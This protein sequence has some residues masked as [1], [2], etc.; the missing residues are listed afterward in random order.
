MKDYSANSFDRKTFILNYEV[1]IL[2]NEI[3]INYADNTK[4]IIAYSSNAEKALL[5]KM[6]K[7]VLSHKNEYE[8]AR[9]KLKDSNN[10]KKIILIAFAIILGISISSFQFGFLPGISNLL[11]NGIMMKMLLKT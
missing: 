1:D 7:Q 3:I 2:N 11:F 9:K 5:E 8:K 6:K 4:D 10:V